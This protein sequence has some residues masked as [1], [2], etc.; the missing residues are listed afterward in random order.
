MLKRDNWTNDEILEILRSRLIPEDEPM[1][2][3]A[4]LAHNCLLD[5]LMDEFASCKYHPEEFGAFA[6]DA[7]A[8]EFVHI[9]QIPDDC[10]IKID[11]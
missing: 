6:Y 3:N 2:L 10:A 11:P 5:S 1:Q 9:G 7:E 8:K 4:L